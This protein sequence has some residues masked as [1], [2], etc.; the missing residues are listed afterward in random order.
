MSLLASV[1]ECGAYNK[2]PDLLSFAK[3]FN[4]MKFIYL[5]RHL[6]TRRSNRHFDVSQAVAEGIHELCIEMGYRFSK[7]G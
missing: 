1:T 7:K 3:K 5:L 4:A 2:Q 6:L